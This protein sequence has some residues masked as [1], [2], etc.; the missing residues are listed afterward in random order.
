MLAVVQDV[1]QAEVAVQDDC[2]GPGVVGGGEN[3]PGRTPPLFKLEVLSVEAR[4]VL[5]EERKFLKC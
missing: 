3:I 5:E 1:V 4:N 2:Q